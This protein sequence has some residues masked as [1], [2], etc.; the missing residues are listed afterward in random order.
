M[1][2]VVVR[3]IAHTDHSA[4]YRS[5][6]LSQGP[7]IYLWIL[8]RARNQLVEPEGIAWETLWEEMDK[9]LCHCV[10]KRERDCRKWGLPKQNPHLRLCGPPLGSRCSRKLIHSSFQGVFSRWPSGLEKGGTLG[11]VPTPIRRSA[12][13]LNSWGLLSWS[14][15]P[16]KFAYRWSAPCLPPPKT[17]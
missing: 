14:G 2:L 9:R 10:Q 5:E 4:K 11:R 17:H 7:F 6:L 12:R 15:T 16:R 1:P 13:T 3:W 8:N